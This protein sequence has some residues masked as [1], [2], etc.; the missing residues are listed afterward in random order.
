VACVA[1]G[2]YL[3]RD[4]II[5]NGDADDPWQTPR[6]HN[7]ATLIASGAGAGLSPIAP[8]TAGSILGVLC[9]WPL[10]SLSLEWL[11][12]VWLC[13]CF[14]AVWAADSAGADWQVVDHPAIVIDEVVGVWLAY[15]IPATLLTVELDTLQVI[16]GALV[17]FR[18]YD[19]AKPWPVNSA[20]R[21]LSRGVGVVADDLVAGAM[22]GFILCLLMTAQLIA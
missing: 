16:L 15:L 5:L 2:C 19:I 3:S 8:G 6:I 10:C 1:T 20:E 11:W 18:I 14:L 17:L 9:L 4:T 21:R 22:A 13:T 7:L 12:L